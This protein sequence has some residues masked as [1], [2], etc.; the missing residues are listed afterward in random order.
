MKTAYIEKKEI[1]TKA[2]LFQLLLS[3]GVVKS[4]DTKIM[5]RLK[6]LK[7][8]FCDNNV[9]YW[10]RSSGESDQTLE[11]FTLGDFVEMEE[12]QEPT[13]PKFTPE[14]ITKIWKYDLGSGEGNMFTDILHL[15]DSAKKD[16]VLATPE[17]IQEECNRLN[18]LCEDS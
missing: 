3:G 7:L 15:V 17:E 1:I 13:P 9:N 11:Y 2:Y 10:V 6:E 12:I 8:F 14:N 16:A 5:Y 4:K 18:K